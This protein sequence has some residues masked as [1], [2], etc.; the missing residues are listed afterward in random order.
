MNIEELIVKLQ[1]AA[2][3]RQVLEAIWRD[4][5]PYGLKQI[6]P[7]TLRELNRIMKWDDSE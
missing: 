2:H 1:E 5:G 6:T 7:E 3:E 4:I